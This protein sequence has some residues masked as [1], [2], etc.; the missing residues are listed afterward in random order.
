MHWKHSQCV[1]RELM[2]KTID[3]QVTTVL[4]MSWLKLLGWDC[5]KQTAGLFQKCFNKLGEID[6]EQIKIQFVKGEK[7][8]DQLYIDKMKLT[9]L[10]MTDMQSNRSET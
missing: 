10:K 6:F 2:I 3:N 9:R 7:K 8:M 1:L 4:G 5:S